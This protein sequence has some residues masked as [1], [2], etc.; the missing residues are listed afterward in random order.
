[1][2]P[3]S[4]AANVVAS[5]SVATAVRKTLSE[6]IASTRSTPEEVRRIE[7][8]VTGVI[9]ILNALVR[10]VQEQNNVPSSRL[11]ENLDLLLRAITLDMNH[12]SEMLRK[13]QPGSGRNVPVKAKMVWLF[14][15]EEMMKLRSRLE[16]HRSTLSLLLSTMQL[17]SMKQIRAR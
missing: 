13:I 12:L 7:E 10:L 6:L 4:I 15:K 3:L 14:Q 9:A 8:E 2:D 16:S 17:A 1:M 5:A 11:L